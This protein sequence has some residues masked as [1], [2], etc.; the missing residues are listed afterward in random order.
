MSYRY[1][2]ETQGSTT[3]EARKYDGPD[4]ADAM[5][6]WSALITAGVEYVMLEAIRE[7]K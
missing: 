5:A 7:P 6:A 4:A 2:V 1:P 3:R